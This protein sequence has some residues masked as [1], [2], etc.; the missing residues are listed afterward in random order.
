M[1]APPPPPFTNLNVVEETIVCSTNSNVVEETIVCSTNLTV[2]EE[3]I[4][5]SIN[6]N[7]VEEMIVDDDHDD[8]RSADNNHYLTNLVDDLCCRVG[9]AFFLKTFR[10]SS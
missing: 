4:V 3:A 2:V 5:C 7:V 10:L 1:T 8:D 6:L 9:H